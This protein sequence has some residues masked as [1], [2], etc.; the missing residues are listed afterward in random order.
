[1]RKLSQVVDANGR[2]VPSALLVPDKV[3]AR[4]L[5]ASTAESATIPA[6]V[7]YVRLSST[8]PFYANFSATAAIPSADITNG[9]SSILIPSSALYEIPTGTTAISLIASAIGVVT[10]EWFE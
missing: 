9:S 2:S 6:G 1:M 7:K 3:D 10:L 8:A 4:V 5:A